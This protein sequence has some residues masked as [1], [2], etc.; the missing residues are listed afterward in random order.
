M[1]F[2]LVY[3]TYESISKIIIYPLKLLYY[4]GPQFMGY[5]GWQGIAKEDICS[6][7]TKVPA[8]MWIEQSKNCTDLIQRHFNSYLVALFSAFYFV[9]VYKIISF[10]WFKYFVLKPLIYELKL[11]W[12]D[13]NNIKKL[14]LN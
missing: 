2:N 11:L 10:L 7:L 9:F 8:L 14:Q 1:L 5:G 13:E 6:Q 4:D 12:N 3:S